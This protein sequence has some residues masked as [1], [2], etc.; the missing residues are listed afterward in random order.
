MLTFR[1]IVIAFLIAF[2]TVLPAAPCVKPDPERR[3]TGVKECLIYRIYRSAII[4]ANPTLI[5]VL[6]GDVSSGG[7]A[8]YHR[9]IA[10]SVARDR[11]AKN[12]VAVALVRPGYEDGDGETSSGSHNGRADHYT[13]QNID[14]ITAVMTRLRER[15][16][17]SSILVLGHS[18]GAAISGVVIG[19]H[20]ALA[21]AAVL[22]S[23]PCDVGRWRSGRRAWVQSESPHLWA[24]KVATTTTVIALSGS[25]D[26][27][28]SPQ[29]A[30]RYVEALNK[31]NIKARFELIPDADHNSAFRSHRVGDAVFEALS[32]N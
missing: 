12:L 28:T 25:R 6:H 13:A 7:P 32:N 17:A 26:D 23:C 22:V 9:K 19:R 8:N 24:D 29:L 20:P 18:G 16:E 5:V 15:F 3:E 10:E 2:P 1:L 11:R 30:Q 4:E 27:N 31:R 14:E 21:S